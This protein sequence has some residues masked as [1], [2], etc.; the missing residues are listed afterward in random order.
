MTFKG[1]GKQ[2]VLSKVSEQEQLHYKKRYSSIIIT[3]TCS[4]NQDKIDSFGNVTAL[5][6]HFFLPKLLPHSLCCI[7]YEETAAI[8]WKTELNTLL[9]QLNLTVTFTA[10]WEGNGRKTNP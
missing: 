9:S 2:M 7:S 10:G 5:L 3:D 4:N 6:K 1:L 8:L